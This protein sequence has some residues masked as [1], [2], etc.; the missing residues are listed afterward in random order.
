MQ[1]SFAYKASTG[2]GVLTE[3][4][5]ASKCV[6]QGASLGAAA[7]FSAPGGKGADESTDVV[8]PKAESE[9][10]FFFLFFVDPTGTLA[11][12]A[13]TRALMRVAK[14]GLCFGVRSL[15]PIR[16]A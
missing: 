1:A 14:E 10:L 8:S 9:S 16:G 4:R 15:C 5:I 3:G 12:F 11:S 2:R 6:D 13:K 7:S